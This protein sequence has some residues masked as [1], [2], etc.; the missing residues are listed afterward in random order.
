MANKRI[1]DNVH[2]LKGTYQP[3]RHGDPETKPDWDE[4][5]PDIPDCVA[6]IPEAAAEWLRV[7]NFVPAGVITQTDRTAFSQ[8]CVLWSEFVKDPEG[9]PS[10]KHA[11]L[12]LVQQELG[13]TPISRGKIGGAPKGPG[14][15]GFQTAPR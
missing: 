8:Y 15:G 6:E 3:C 1:P 11:Q 13:F 2:K 10:S 12:K 5:F 14:E 9:F 4:S 7:S